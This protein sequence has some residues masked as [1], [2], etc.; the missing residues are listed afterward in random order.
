MNELPTDFDTNRYN[1][2]LFLSPWM[3][4]AITTSAAYFVTH[5]DGIH[6][7]THT[8]TRTHT[9]THIHTYT[10]TGLT[11]HHTTILPACTAAMAFPPAVSMGM[12]FYYLVL[13]LTYLF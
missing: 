8:H 9:H 13:L 2:I 3:L 10:C 12:S 6:T 4:S 7:H 11:P 5:I 1:I